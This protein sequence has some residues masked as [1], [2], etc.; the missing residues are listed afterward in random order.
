MFE[1]WREMGRITQLEAAIA[2]ILLANQFRD[3][4]QMPIEMLQQ[5]M[6]KHHEPEAIMHRTRSGYLKKEELLDLEFRP[7]QGAFDVLCLELECRLVRYNMQRLGSAEDL[8]A[9]LMGDNDPSQVDQEVL[10]EGLVGS[11]YTSNLDMYVRV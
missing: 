11:E 3:V 6:L 2:Q 9:E 7:L 1:Y 10:S 4:K 8:L 5:Y